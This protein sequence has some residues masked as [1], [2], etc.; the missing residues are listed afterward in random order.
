V[1]YCGMQTQTLDTAVVNYVNDI[2]AEY[3][4]RIE[5]IKN[6][7]EI[8]LTGCPNLPIYK[9]ILTLCCKQNENWKQ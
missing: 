5:E 1:P 9:F 8:R 6:D 2:K 3:E 7:Y 4:Q